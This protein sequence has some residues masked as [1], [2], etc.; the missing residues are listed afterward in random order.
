MYIHLCINS[1]IKLLFNH[2]FIYLI[3]YLFNHF[4]IYLLFHFLMK[5]IISSF[6]ICL[7]I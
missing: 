3:I 2:L 5:S 7:F 6:I 1:F 4:S